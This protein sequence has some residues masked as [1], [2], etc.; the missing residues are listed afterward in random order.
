MHYIS[1]QSRGQATL[2]PE[3]LD[4]YITANNPVQFIDCFV[5]T[6]DFA[7]LGFKQAKLARTGRPP[8]NLG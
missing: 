1:E 5:N 7:A 4:D 8:Y 2:F 6:L 3:T